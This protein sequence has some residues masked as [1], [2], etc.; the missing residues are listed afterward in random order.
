MERV[1]DTSTE[2]QGWSEWAD[3]FKPTKNKFSKH[4]E[5]M[6]ETYGEELE[7]VKSIHPNFIW[8]LVSGDG[9]DLIVAGYSYVN[10][11]GY[12]ITENPWGDDGDSCLL[13]VEEECECYSEDEDVLVE[14]K[15]NWGDPDCEKC[16]G[17]G[18]VTNYVG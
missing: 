7:Y 18:Y 16:E 9:C 6:Y 14:R 3:K 13:S 10:R 17:A 15:D 2:Y 8:T 5:L 4:D 11:L 1:E 12:Y